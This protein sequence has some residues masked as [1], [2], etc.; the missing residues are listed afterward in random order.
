MCR[1]GSSDLSIGGYLHD[2]AKRKV[3]RGVGSRGDERRNGLEESAIARRTISIH[4]GG[5]GIAG[6]G[7]ALLAADGASGMISCT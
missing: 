1:D 7:F 4:V 3:M 6:T 5:L 2:G